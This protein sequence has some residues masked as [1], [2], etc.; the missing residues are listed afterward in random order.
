MQAE[1][2]LVV[3]EVEATKILHDKM[4][5]RFLKKYADVDKRQANP[6]DLNLKLGIGE[7]VD[8]A[9]C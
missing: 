8:Q 5:R 2:T 6:C 1:E 9:G 3:S 7:L 4:C